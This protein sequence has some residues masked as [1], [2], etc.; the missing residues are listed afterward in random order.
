[1]TQCGVE[2]KKALSLKSKYC[3]IYKYS[4]IIYKTTNS[5]LFEKVWMTYL[6]VFMFKNH[7]IQ[8]F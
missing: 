1:M 5:R 4:L 8:N 2:F 7:I 3:E 6:F